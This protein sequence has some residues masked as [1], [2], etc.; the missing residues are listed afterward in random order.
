MQKTDSSS[1]I[2]TTMVINESHTVYI[3][4]CVYVTINIHVSRTKNGINVKLSNKLKK[5]RR[6]ER[7]TYA[8]AL[9]VFRSLIGRLIVR[10]L[11]KRLQAR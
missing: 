4:T 11:V 8:H 3:Q 6:K 10:I 9:I 2:T 1:T 7:K 5:Q